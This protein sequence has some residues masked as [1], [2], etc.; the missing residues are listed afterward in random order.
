MNASIMTDYSKDAALLFILAKVD[1]YKGETESFENKYKRSFLA[2]EQ[3]THS[4]KGQEDF[5][6]EEDLEDWEFAVKSLEYWENQYHK[7]RTNA[8]VA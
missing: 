3:E 1:Q 2:L 7:L 6:V 5:Q 8:A 4:V